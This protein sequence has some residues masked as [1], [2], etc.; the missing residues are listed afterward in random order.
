MQDWRRI[1]LF[2]VAGGLN[3]GFGFAIYALFVYL[4]FPIWATVTL[5]MIAALIFNYLTYG[6]MV[7]KDLSWRNLPLFVIFYA[8]LAALNTAL[9]HGLN[10]LGFGALMAQAILVP[11]LALIS[12]VGLSYFVFHKSQTS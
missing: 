10:G 7:F 4:Q 3:T 6:G 11:P 12:Y 8:S 9:L 2:L 1:G 5:S